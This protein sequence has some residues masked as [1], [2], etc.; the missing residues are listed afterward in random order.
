MTLT[1]P[2]AL[3][4]LAL[5]APVVLA[6]LY[7]RNRGKR[8][9]PSAILLRVIRDD[10]PSAR[11]ARARLRHHLSLALVL[12]ALAAAALAAI[13]PTTGAGR[14]RRVI[15]V[16][17]TSASMGAR[18]GDGGDRLTRA[19][20]ALDRLARD[21]GGDDELALIATGAS[22]GVVVAPTRAHA[23][24]VGRARAL[25][26]AG[27]A[28]ANTDDALA[29]RLADGLCRDPALTT[30]VVVSD[31]AGLAAPPTRCPLRHVA[32]GRAAANLGV[33]ALSARLVDG[34][35]LYDVHVAVGSTA[36]IERRVEV[37]LTVD[38]EA[39]EVVGLDVPA[40]GD[41]DR[42][43]RVMIDGGRTLTAAVRPGDGGAAADALALDDRAAIPLPDHGPVPVLLVTRRPRS[44]MAEVLRLHPQVRLAVA[45]PDALPPDPVALI[46]LEDEPVGPLPPAPHVVGLGVVPPGAPLGLGAAAG[47]RAIVRW[48]FDAPWFRFLDLRDVVVARARLVTGGVPIVE[49]GAGPLVASASWDDRALL[50][51]GFTIA[52]T[53]LSLRAAFPNLIA[54]L[55]DWA[56]PRRASTA[57]RTGVLAAAESHLGPAALPGEPAAAARGWR[58]DAVVARL[59]ILA[60]IALLLAEQVVSLARRRRAS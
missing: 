54:N 34:L 12:A 13:G 22:A 3:G 39:V 29:F 48:D 2:W 4:L 9:V 24:V 1:Q 5:A 55:V 37:T 7:R 8:A 51:T 53:D 10:Q 32:I 52:D 25:A 50:V 15:V 17:D 6:Y 56:A 33:T 57:P 41:A 20:D 35:G 43:L 14:A 18:D 46:V 59:A 36:D 16:V 60:A 31:G 44:P 30:I 45:A 19:A 28:G 21:L 26:A 40:G 58:G 23:D 27:A 42:T 38:G 11:R 49:S 47:E